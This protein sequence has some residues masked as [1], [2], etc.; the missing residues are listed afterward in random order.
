MRLTK[1][2]NKELEVIKSFIPKWCKW[3]SI[4]DKDIKMFFEWSDN[5]MHKNKVG[6]N[7]IISGDYSGLNSLVW[8][9]I[10]RERNLAIKK[11]FDEQHSKETQ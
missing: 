5:G 3:D 4:T 1:K 6:S 11:Q 10:W 2:Q 7:P 9:K 8:G